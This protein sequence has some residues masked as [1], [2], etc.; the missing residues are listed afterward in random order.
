[1][2]LVAGGALAQAPVNPRLPS[3]PPP[4]NVRPQNPVI[5][6]PQGPA[7]VGLYMASQDN[8]GLSGLTNVVGLNLPRGQYQVIGHVVFSNDEATNGAVACTLRLNG[9][10]LDYISTSA[11]PNSREEHTLL[12]VARVDAL[13]RGRLDI[14]CQS[15]S[16]VRVTIRW[17]RV[18][19]L[20][21]SQVSDQT[22]ARGATV[23]G[24]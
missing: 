17:A 16:H 14:A 8:V 9:G 21:V 20:V 3:P 4:A 2:L 18:Q 1:M 5:A 10:E 7:G 19:A 12:G 11:Q 15:T 24:H 22:P 6:V 13:L 23:P